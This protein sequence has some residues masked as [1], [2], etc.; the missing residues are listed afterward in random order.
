MQGRLGPEGPVVLV[1]LMCPALT[2]EV[3]PK[4]RG[5]ANFSDQDLQRFADMLGLQGIWPGLRSDIAPGSGA[6]VSTASL[7]CLARAA[8]Y[9]GDD[10]L[11]ARACVAIEGASDPLMFDA[12]DRIIWASR[13]ARIVRPV[14]SPPACEIVGGLWRGPVSTD[15]WDSRFPDIA[16]LI[17]D[18]AEA[19]GNLNR[20][21]SLARISAQRC[22]DM[23]G[24]EDPMAIL[25][26][27]LGA[28]GHVRAHTGSARGLIFAPGDVP[29]QAESA[30]R[31]AGLTNVFRF[32]TGAS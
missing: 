24:P 3:S 4:A 10:L 31:E 30:M 27:K 13:E 20:A 7:V 25:C 23:R 29:S 15:A 2:V 22:S 17:G 9:R 12:P 26:D 5:G 6:G 8:G 19:T 18:W 32:R 28:L 14:P 21:A 16:D 11:L 1:T